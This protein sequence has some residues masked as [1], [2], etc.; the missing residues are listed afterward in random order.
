MAEIVISSF[1]RQF[2]DSVAAKKWS[3]VIQEINCKV[4]I[5]NQMLK[6]QREAIN[7]A[8]LVIDGL[9]V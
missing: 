8:W 5:Y 3:N 7:N 2:G 9:G 6:I 4:M 1:K